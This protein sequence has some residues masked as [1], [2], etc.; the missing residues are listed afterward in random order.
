MN[1]ANRIVQV[2]AALVVSVALQESA[3][4]AEQVSKSTVQT[5][6][7]KLEW[8]AKTGIGYDANIYRTHK[9][10]YIDHYP[11]TALAVSPVTQSGFFVPYKAEVDFKMNTATNFGLVAGGKVDGESYLSHNNANTFNYEGRFGVN[12][13]FA[14]KGARADELYAGV[15]IGHHKKIYVDRDSG[16]AKQ[17][18]G[19]SNI[20][21]RYTYD[22]TGFEAE[23]RKNS[24]DTFRFSANAT[25]ENRAYADP[26]VVA[27]YDHQFIQLGGDI[28]FVPAKANLLKLAYTYESSDFSA[29]RSRD[30]N[31]SYLAANPLLVYTDHNYKFYWRTHLGEPLVAYA[32]VALTKHSDAFVN[33]SGYTEIEYGARL[34]Y[35]ATKQLQGR[36]ALS[37]WGRNYSSAYAY[38]NPTQPRLTADGV[39]LSLKGEYELIPHVSLWAEM[40]NRTWNTN[41]L[42]YDYKRYQFLVGA[43]ME[44]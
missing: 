39:V 37:K 9:G 40:E 41:D 20:S 1:R 30:K 25:L 31:G 4:A 17:T 18:A 15:L 16:V 11:A 21:N 14:G 44:Y 32:D 19:G 36:F 13:V 12:N 27:K 26:I 29:R 6:S 28:E 38:D 35:K 23:Y 5:A 22:S 34:L 42:R 8:S 3:N 7:Q 33:Y 43:V 2:V 10:N 24:D